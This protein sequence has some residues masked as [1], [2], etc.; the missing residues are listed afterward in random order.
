[1]AAWRRGFVDLLEVDQQIITKVTVRVAI[2][3][4]GLPQKPQALKIHDSN[5]QEIW[6]STC[7]ALPE[8]F[9]EA[10]RSQHIL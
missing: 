3:C 5:L 10:E 4:I 9:R 6:K 8:S 1:M 2:R 7:L